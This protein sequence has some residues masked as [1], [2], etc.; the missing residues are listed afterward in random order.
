[1]IN[2]FS[3]LNLRG[4]SFKSPT[5]ALF[6]LRICIYKIKIWYGSNGVLAALGCELIPNDHEWQCTLAPRYCMDS[7]IYEKAQR[8]KNL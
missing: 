4:V 3:K 6:R 7:Y 1:M 2:N 8:T 5:K